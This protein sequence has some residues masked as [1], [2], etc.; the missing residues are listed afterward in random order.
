[1]RGVG[2]RKIH[3]TN[4]QMGFLARYNHYPFEIISK[5]LKITNTHVRK[6]I[7]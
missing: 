3:D 7:F 5:L 2:E 6:S 1:M 4:W